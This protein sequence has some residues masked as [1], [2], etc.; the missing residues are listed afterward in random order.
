[1]KSAATTAQGSSIAAA[2]AGNPAIA[3]QGARTALILSMASCLANLDGG[4]AD[5]ND[6][7]FMDYPIGVPIGAG[8]YSM[9]AGAAM[10]NPALVF[11]FA[12]LHGGVMLLYH[13]AMGGR[14]P[15]QEVAGKFYFPSL[16]AVVLVPL[17]QPTVTAATTLLREHESLLEAFAGGGSMLLALGFL[18]LLFRMSVLRFGA[19]FFTFAQLGL[20]LPNA[21][22]RFL[23][24]PGEYKDKTLW[25]DPATDRLPTVE[26]RRAE[27]KKLLDAEA[28][29]WRL[30]ELRTGR[31]R[32]KREVR[33]CEEA[34][35]R[36]KKKRDE[37]YAKLLS[38][39]APHLRPEA[40][41]KQNF[42]YFDLYRPYRVWFVC[43]E[44]GFT[45]AF[46][47]I[48]GWQPNSVLG[49]KVIVVAMVTLFAILFL[50]IIALR[51]YVARFELIFAFV[52]TGLQ[53]VSAG[54]TMFYVM[55]NSK[56]AI[57]IG[58]WTA[59]S[60][61]YLLSVKAVL[62]LVIL[63]YELVV[64]KCCA[65]VENHDEVGDTK[66][67]SLLISP[68]TELERGLLKAPSSLGIVSPTTPVPPLPANPLALSETIDRD[69]M[70]PKMAL[71]QRNS[72]AA[73][74]D[75][76][77]ESWSTPPVPLARDRSRPVIVR[78]PRWASELPELGREFG[79]DPDSLW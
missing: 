57:D 40:W 29:H 27:E 8:N 16:E 55:D 46:G 70:V 76:N 79:Q 51:P 33:E 24:G 32:T 10:L 56:P 3:A 39:R 17:L 2:A 38:L 61:M 1:V 7:G 60:G 22:M 9:L 50:S 69:L 35:E 44:Y 15:L 72:S 34:F 26:E 66:L 12:A 36:E 6:L 54:S 67:F 21:L 13:R 68:E 14:V 63:A 5:T 41:V 75:R 20:P 28:D 18:W 48:Q 19:R 11:G 78:K 43:I 77:V 37:A 73:V 74:S 23:K 64:E 4:N 71:G 42:M 49:C 47:V 58:G 53:L 31:R 30:Q 52:V 45:I 65:K 62:D 25:D 59:T